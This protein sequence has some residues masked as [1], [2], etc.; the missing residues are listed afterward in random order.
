MTSIEAI[1]DCGLTPGRISSRRRC[2]E[3]RLQDETKGRKSTLKLYSGPASLFTSK[4][5]IALAEKN[6]DYERI[7]VG[8]SLES[9]YLPHHPDVVALNP[10]REVPVL[11]DGDL[12]VH[13]STLILEY[14]EE[15]NPTPSL[16]PSGIAERARCRQAE[17]RADEIIFPH[18]WSLIQEGLY[19]SSGGGRDEERLG[20]ARRELALLHREINS[21]LAD[22]EHLCS[23]FG[24]ADI[25]TFVMLSAGATLGAP[26]DESL[27][28]LHEWFSRVGARPVVARELAELQAVVSRALAEHAA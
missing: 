14:L 22:R 3:R 18:V 15:R 5:R 23:D 13:D 25:A 16:Y 21:E 8:W 4:V 6:L 7:E 27:D 17:A 28:N 10:K 24:V 20:N 26:P 9:A 12:V 2:L 11:I 1:L 19:P